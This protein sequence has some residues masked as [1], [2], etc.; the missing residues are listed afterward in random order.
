MSM[1]PIIGI[2]MLLQRLGPMPQQ[3]SGSSQCDMDTSGTQACLS[4]DHA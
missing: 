2:T 4:D 1:R 3:E